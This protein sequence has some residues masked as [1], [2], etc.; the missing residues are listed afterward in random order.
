MIDYSMTVTMR[1]DVCGYAESAKITTKGGIRQ[2]VEEILPGW[3]VGRSSRVTNNY[4]QASHWCRECR[5]AYD[6]AGHD[7]IQRR[8]MEAAQ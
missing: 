8:Q 3:V 7:A 6:N 2:S 4:R 5:E 1:C